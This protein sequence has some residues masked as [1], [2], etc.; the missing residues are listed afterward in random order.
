MR[1]FVSGR[2]S[3]HLCCS[4][5]NLTLLSYKSLD[6]SNILNSAFVIFMSIDPS[7]WHVFFVTKMYRP[8]AKR[9]MYVWTCT[10]E[11]LSCNLTCYNVQYVCIVFDWGNFY[12][13]SNLCFFAP[14]FM[15]RTLPSQVFA[16]CSLQPL[17]CSLS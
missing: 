10:K 13:E 12:A 1:C 16:V 8:R 11:N 4:A 14:T 3:W 5:Q 2:R 6:H 15:I 7:K 9:K 17:V